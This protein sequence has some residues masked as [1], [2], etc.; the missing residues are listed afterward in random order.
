MKNL[1][2]YELYGLRLRIF[3]NAGSLCREAQLLL[4][5][6]YYA[7]A[8]LLAHLAVEELGK[9]PIV[10]S[11]IRAIRDGTVVDWKATQERFRNHQSKVYSDHLHSCVFGIY[12]PR[13]LEDPRA[14][15]T[16][17]VDLK[18]DTLIPAGRR[19]FFRPKE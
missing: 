1:T 5:H 19:S 16:F 11:V 7:R 13:W 2:I 18:N 6:G 17:H 3:E 9:I 12:D 8:Y 4:D 10:A 14:M 15:S